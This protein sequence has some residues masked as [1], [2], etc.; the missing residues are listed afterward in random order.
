MQQHSMPQR[1]ARHLPCLLLPW[2]LGA[3]AGQQHAGDAF[4]RVAGVAYTERAGVALTADLYRP[5]QTTARAAAVVVLHGGSWRKGSPAQME[6]TAEHLARA[7]YVV[8]N[9]RYRLAP[10]HRYPAAL[11]DARDAVRFLRANAGELGIDARRI[12]AFGYSAGGHLAMLLATDPERAG[13]DRYPGVSAEIAAVVAGGTP[14]DLT[15][16]ADSRAVEGFLGATF[17]D[18]PELYRQAS[19]ITHVGS[20]DPP[21]FL[22]HGRSDWIVGIEQT[23]ALAAKLRDAAVPVEVAEYTFG[24]IAVFLFD[25][26][27]LEAATRFLDRHLAAPR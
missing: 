19:P 9:I 22:Y 13:S 21:A 27:E 17:A 25:D 18:R 1:W 26:D 6:H 10:A 4:T 3:C 12:G 2:L 11:D 24:H 7:G 8:A 20:G 14:A 23:R 16:F 15:R 5:A